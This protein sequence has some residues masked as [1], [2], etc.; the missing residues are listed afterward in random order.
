MIRNLLNMT[1]GVTL[2]ECV[3][4]VQTWIRGY[5]GKTIKVPG[6]HF[7]YDSMSSYILSACAESDGNESIGLPAAETVQTDAYHRYILGSKP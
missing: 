7:D 5:L 3:M 2:T 4:V 6:K 1:S